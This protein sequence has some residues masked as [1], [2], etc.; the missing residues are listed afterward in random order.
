VK[1]ILLVVVALMALTDVTH[2][3][4]LQ[5]GRQSVDGSLFL[6]PSAADGHEF[7]LRFSYGRNVIDDLALSSWLSATDDDTHTSYS[8]GASLRKGFDV[9]E[10]LYPYVAC[11]LGFVMVDAD[12]SETDSASFLQA[13]LGSRYFLEASTRYYLFSEAVFTVASEDIFP[14]DEEFESTDVF[15]RAGFGFVF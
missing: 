14:E 2:A 5:K 11:G 1:K 10:H 12:H 15:F 7:R 6:D 8:L 4:S 13:A 3:V 9:H